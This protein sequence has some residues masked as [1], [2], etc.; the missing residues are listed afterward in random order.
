MI[1]RLRESEGLQDQRV[2]VALKKPVNEEGLL[3][4]LEI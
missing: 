1:R 2:H 3:V 4:S